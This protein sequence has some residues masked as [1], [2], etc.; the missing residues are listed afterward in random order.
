MLGIEQA[1]KSRAPAG[2]DRYGYGKWDQW[3]L[4]VAGPNERQEAELWRLN[5]RAPLI[6]RAQRGK[7]ANTGVVQ[8]QMRESKAPNSKKRWLHSCRGSRCQ[9]TA[10]TTGI[11]GL[12]VAG[13]REDWGEPWELGS[14]G[15]K[16][17]L[18]AGGANGGP[19]KGSD[20]GCG[21]AHLS[22][23]ATEPSRA[24]QGLSLPENFS[25]SVL[26]ALPHLH[27]HPDYYCTRARLSDCG[28][29]HTQTRT[30]ACRFRVPLK[31]QRGEWRRPPRRGPG[32]LGREPGA[33]QGVGVGRVRNCCGSLLGCQKWF[34]TSGELTTRRCSKEMLT[35]RDQESGKR[36]YSASDM[37][38]PHVDW[39]SLE[40][41][42]ARKGPKQQELNV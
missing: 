32:L 40:R 42:L 2:H 38:E 9:S 20:G 36:R 34:V 26:C 11:S 18:W 13:G 27:H 6:A 25:R 3:D 23:L 35:G 39:A 22:I 10:P 15:G 41:F 24:A 28:C 12:S 14:L 8:G 4:G 19:G 1:G 31:W 21:P 29:A 33:L 17:W 7:I 37:P 5:G 16:L 30:H